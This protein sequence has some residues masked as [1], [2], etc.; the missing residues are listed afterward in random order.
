MVVGIVVSGLARHTALELGEALASVIRDVGER[1]LVV[2][3]SD[4]THFLSASDAAVLDRLALDRFEAL[5]ASGL[6]HVVEANA[7]SMCGVLPATIALAAASAL[8]AR[9]SR[10]VDY[11]H[12]GMTTGDHARVV[13]YAGAIIV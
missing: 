9:S 8:G 3:S 12:S 11:T 2:A 7:I 5:D 13:A 6:F 10:V 1:V 4:M